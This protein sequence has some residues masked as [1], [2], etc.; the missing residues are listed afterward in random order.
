MGLFTSRP[1]KR[2]QKSSGRERSDAVQCDQVW[3]GT[4]NSGWSER[5][6][7]RFASD[8]TAASTTAIAS[9]LAVAAHD[10]NRFGQATVATLPA[11]ATGSRGEGWQECKV[12]AHPRTTARKIEI[13]AIIDLMTNSFGPLGSGTVH[14]ILHHAKI[15]AG[16][17][18][19]NPVPTDLRQLC[20]AVMRLFGANAEEKGLRMVVNISDD[21]PLLMSA[22]KLRPDQLLAYLVSNAGKF[23]PSGEVTVAASAKSARDRSLIVKVSV[24]DTGPRL[25]EAEI[26]ILFDAFTQIEAKSNLAVKGTDLGLPTAR[27]LAQLM[28]GDIAIAAA[29]GGGFCFM[30]E[31]IARAVK[32]TAGPSQTVEEPVCQLAYLSFLAAE[33]NR[34]NRMALRAFLREKNV[35]LTKAENGEQA[36]E[37]ARCEMFDVLLMDMRMPI[38]DGEAAFH[39]LRNEGNM[40]PIVALT[41]NAMP[42]DRERYLVMAMDGYLSKLL[43]KT[44]LLRC[45]EYHRKTLYIAS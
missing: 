19:L 27:S 30:L 25:S 21:V 31:F 16:K 28:Q 29:Q 2:I 38:M 33:D 34:T 23:T 18:E 43:R 26:D 45:L 6:L 24:N 44:A 4:D 13:D 41:A 32:G 42:E 22:D 8:P 7:A 39:T 5:R 14:D 1:R 40:V 37:K 3:F 12:F 36:F 11:P 35:I 10:G 15:E 20:D 17:L 9:F